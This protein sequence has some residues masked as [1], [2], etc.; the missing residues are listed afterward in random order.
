MSLPDF[1]ERQFVLATDLDG[2]FLGGTDEDRRQLY[3]WI[4]DNRDSVGLIFVSGRDPEFMIETCS[5]GDLPWPEYVIGDVGTT[6]ARV[7]DGDIRPIEALEEDISGCVCRKPHFAIGSVIT[8]TLK[9]MTPP[10]P[11]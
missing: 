8:T 11:I 6:I 10:P 2:T 4:E 7:E 5:S 9:A 3:D 1:H